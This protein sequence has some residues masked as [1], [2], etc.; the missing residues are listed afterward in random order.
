MTT[1]PITARVAL[2]VACHEAVIRQTYKDSVGV[3]TWSV[4]LTNATGHDV[5]RYIGKP[6]SLQHCLE[7]FIWALERYAAEVRQA[8]AGHQLTEAQFAA[9]LSFHWN[10]GAIKLASW[11]KRWKSG[12]VKGARANFMLYNKPAEIIERRK[13]ERDLFFDGI[14]SNRGTMPEYTRLTK[15]M[16]PVWSSRVERDVRAEIEALLAPKAPSV[17]L[18]PRPEQASGFFAAIAAFIARFFK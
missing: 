6:A 5:T 9:A 18:T 12:D 11:V 17:S 4:G 2:E 16:T 7:I 8:F 15:R 13:A 14:W 10:T 3:L 1:N